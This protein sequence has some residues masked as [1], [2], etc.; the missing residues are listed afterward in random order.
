MAEIGGEGASLLIARL[1]DMVELRDWEP[2]FYADGHAKPG[3]SYVVV[4]GG[5]CP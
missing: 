2:T 1:Q 4:N 3:N 5:L